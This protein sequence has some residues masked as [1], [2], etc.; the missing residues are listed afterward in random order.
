MASQ[1]NQAPDRHRPP[2]R[3]QP[4]GR[5]ARVGSALAGAVIGLGAGAAAWAEEADAPATSE[6]WAVHGQT[7]FVDQGN[8]AFRS[9]YRGP[10]SLD[11]GARGRETFDATLYLGVRLWAGA[12]AWA[13]PEVD[14]GFG[15]SDTLG[16]A[17]F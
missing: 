14:Q 16:I 15:L 4:A 17:G 8:L 12:E 7:T 9:P 2:P 5:L 1:P 13:D 10:N 11:P 3:P 6:A